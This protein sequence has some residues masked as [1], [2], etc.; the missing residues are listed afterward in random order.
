MHALE[1]GVGRPRRVLREEHGELL[2]ADPVGAPLTVL[3]ADDVGDEP[4]HLVADRVAEAVVDALEVVD[5]DQ[6]ERHQACSSVAVASASPQLELERAVVA[7][8]GE[9]VGLGVT[10]GEHRPVG[11]ALVQGQREHRAGQ[12]EL[13]RRVDLPQRRRE[14]RDERHDREGRAGVAQVAARGLAQRDPVGERDRDRDERDVGDDVR[15]AAGEDEDG[16]LAGVAGADRAAVPA[17]QER[18]QRRCERRERVGARVERAAQREAAL[19]ALHDG[20]GHQGGEDRVLPAEQDLR[21]HQE[22]EGERDLAG[23][24]LVERHRLE[25]GGQRCRRKHEHAGQ[26]GSVGG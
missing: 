19:D 21:G 13:E 2:A 3:L 24:L 12:Q 14:R 8:A 15:G 4:Q 17:E 26:G 23:A 20:G 7:Q 9:R 25:L 22:D 10:D 18:G 16:Q 1:R 5:V 6:T 11:V